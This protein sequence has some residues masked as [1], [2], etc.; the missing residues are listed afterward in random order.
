MARR[1]DSQPP[2]N[3][4][5]NCEERI[6]EL[7]EENAALRNATLSFGELAERLSKNQRPGAPHQEMRIPRSD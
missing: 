1:D 4:L 5:A 6:E 3:A 7:K 2:E